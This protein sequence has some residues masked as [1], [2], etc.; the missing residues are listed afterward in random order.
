MEQ[1]TDQ[2]LIAAYLKK[3]DEQSLEELVRRYLPL[4]YGF[5]R[6]YTGN[7]DCA[8]DIAQETFVKAWRNLKKFDRSKSFKT[9]IF[10]IAKN[11]AIDWLKKKRDVSFSSL[12]ADRTEEDQAFIDRIHDSQ[13][14]P[15]E[16][17]ARGMEQRRLSLAMAQLPV[18][19]NS[20]LNLRHYSELTF[21]EI[22]IRL[23]Q[24]LNT[25]KSRYRRGL[26]L[27]KKLL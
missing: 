13:P 10:T 16:L 3:G 7:D 22:G 12:E 27:L 17:T 5:V 9:W 26:A 25:V 1:A 15:A 8:A 6:N 20:V 24:P 14:S 2:R 21:R 4:V 23:K 19:Y 11:T 18:A